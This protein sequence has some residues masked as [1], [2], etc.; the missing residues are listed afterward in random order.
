MSQ[1]RGG[2]RMHGHGGV[3]ACGT[4]GDLQAVLVPGAWGGAGAQGRAR[5]PRT[6]YVGPGVRTVPR[7]PGA[8]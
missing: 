1:E 8:Q 2:E 3:R 7:A 5:S 4:L 6:W